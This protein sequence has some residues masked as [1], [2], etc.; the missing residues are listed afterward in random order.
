MIKR[1]WWI[2]RTYRRLIDEKLVAGDGAVSGGDML[3]GL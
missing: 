1:C 2:S 3:L